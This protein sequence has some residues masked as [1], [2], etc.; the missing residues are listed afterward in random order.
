[1]EH[2][3]DVAVV[4]AGQAGLAAS[5]HLMRRGIEHVVLE[6]G[7][8]GETWRTQR[9]DSFALNTPRW[10]SRMPGEPRDGIDRDAFLSASAWIA[11]LEASAVR[12]RLP[13]RERTTVRSIEH[14]ADGAFRVV[15]AGPD[16]GVEELD[17]R[18]V[19]VASGI[20]NVPR[21]PA[22]GSSLPREVR[23][24]T[25][26]S[27]R[28]PEALPPGGVLVVGGA[29]SG[30]QIAEELA[31]AGRSVYLATS[32]VGRIRRR[33]RGRDMF[34]WLHL[35]GFWE[36][37][38]GGL[39]DPAMARWP[40]PQTSGIGP[41]GHTVSLQT[42]A[43]LG[44]RLLGRPRAIE[45]GRILVDDTLG[46]AITFADRIAV[47]LL[48]TAD[49]TIE[50]AGIDAPPAEADPADE[51]HPDPASVHSPPV[52]DV[53]ASDISSVIWTI[54]FDGDFGYLPA[55]ALADTGRPLTDGLAGSLPG[56]HHIGFPWLTK[57]RSGIIDGVDGDGASI[58]AAISSRLLRA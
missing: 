27:Y 58:A 4:G 1:M 53:E 7:R 31:L 23:Q 21:I 49:R 48:R 50:A 2:S 43:A 22:F 39:P 17:A 42:L 36:Q 5:H 9:W 15:V 18:A 38:R 12:D 51:P 45:G 52:L 56:L 26:A 41:G 47:E 34:E 29:Q 24:L 35:S 11:C 13:V 10:M 25:A 44:V 8:I 14:R 37:T 32:S 54:G 16:G 28:S 3:V 6:R 57:R 20:L 19:I 40:N 55:A 30:V 33:Y 46:A